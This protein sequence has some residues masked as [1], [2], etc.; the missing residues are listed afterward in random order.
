V[1]LQNELTRQQARPMGQTVKR[2]YLPLILLIVTVAPGTSGRAFQFFEPVQPPR[3]VQVMAHRGA[4]GQAPENTRPAIQH[5][6]EDGFEWVEIDL[7]LTRDGKHVLYHDSQLE[8]KTDGTGRITD[9]RLADLKKLDAG[10]KFATRFAGERLLTLQEAFEIAR[11]KINLYLDCKAI[12]P[13]LLVQEILDAKMERQVV[14][15][16]KVETLLRIRTASNGRVPIMPKW[17]PANGTGEWIA[18]L[19]PAAVEI[20]ANE[21]TPEICRVFHRK[22]IKVQ[23]K[24]LGKEWDRPEVWDKVI[25]A[26]ADWLQT[27]LAEE[28]I[29]RSVWQRVPKRP[30][31]ISHHRG[32][33]RYAPEN[34]LPAFEKSIRL[35][36][37]FVEFDVRSTSDG[38]FFLLHDSDLRRTTNSSGPI[39]DVSSTV[40]RGLD[41][42]S[43]FGKPFAGE[44]PP[45]LDEFLSAVAGKVDLYFDAKDISPE[46]LMTAIEKYHLADRTIVY[47]S[48]KYL[49]KLRELNP[50]IRSLPPLHDLSELEMIASTLKPYAV[51]AKWEILTQDLIAQCHAKGILV[52]SDSMRNH[53]RIEDFERAIQWGID[54]IQTDHPLRVIRAIELITA[55]SA[56]GKRQ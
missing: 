8:S 45:T 1:L 21:V 27:D 7:Q 18:R 14:V 34:T 47:Q 49:Q 38:Q 29:A 12:N 54:L 37:D 39:G 51:D 2:N 26:G 13:E 6:I 48:V 5:A 56:K 28:I 46:S 42:G 40:V 43:W 55:T 17:Y 16:S 32:A 22:G 4:S 33:N 52:F 44:K 11:G 20:D 53:E 35:G 41:A 15:F 50:R 25:A 36:A 24:V 10:L 31:H 30:V 9:H 23:A 19:Q 3:P